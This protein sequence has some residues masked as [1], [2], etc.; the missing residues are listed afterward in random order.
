MLAA[1]SLGLL[2]DVNDKAVSRLTK[3]IASKRKIPVF[4]KSKPRKAQLTCAALLTQGSHA[5]KEEHARQATGG[6]VRINASKTIDTA[7][8]NIRNRAIKSFMVQDT[9]LQTASMDCKLWG[10][11]RP[12]LLLDRDG[13]EAEANLSVQDPSVSVWLGKCVPR[14]LA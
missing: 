9:A 1:N 2:H 3:K 14:S 12:L 8:S 10:A 11:I 6:D 5:V 7:Q 13:F 4:S